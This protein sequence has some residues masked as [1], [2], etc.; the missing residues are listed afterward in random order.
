MQSAVWVMVRRQQQQ[1]QDQERKF[2]KEPERYVS[3]YQ[4]ATVMKADQEQS[5][6][7]ALE[8]GIDPDKPKLTR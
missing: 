4:R 5:R 7:E 3:D 2:E 1:R 8:R 6:R